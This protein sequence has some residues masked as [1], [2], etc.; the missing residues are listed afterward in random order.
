MAKR[1]SSNKILNFLSISHNILRQRKINPSIVWNM[2]M[3]N[4]ERT[5]LLGNKIFFVY[6][7]FKKGLR[8][9]I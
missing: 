3:E 8:N 4:Y 5:T 1:K 7:N 9:K 6:L 2:E